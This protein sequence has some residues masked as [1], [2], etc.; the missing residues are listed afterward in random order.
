MTTVN[1]ATGRIIWSLESK[2]FL[3]KLI[4][5]NM[6]ILSSDV[7]AET[8]AQK[9]MAWKIIEKSFAEDGMLCQLDKIKRLWKRMKESTR[10]TVKQINLQKRRRVKNV[11]VLSQLD[12]EIL[13][14]ITINEDEVS[15]RKAKVRNI[16]IYCGFISVFCILCEYIYI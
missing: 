8:M 12:N 16:Y 15:S 11:K 4:K 14:F 2:L 6:I 1:Q 10:H 9:E 3:L 7:S 5:E 13:K